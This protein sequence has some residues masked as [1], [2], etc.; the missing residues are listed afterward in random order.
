MEVR[1]DDRFERTP[2][3]NISLD[4][5]CLEF[6]RLMNKHMGADW[7]LRRT[8][9]ALEKM[10]NGPLID[11]SPAERRDLMARVR[12]SNARVAREYFGGELQDSDDPLFRPRSD[13]RPRTSEHVLDGETAV[14]MA[15]ALM[16]LRPAEDPSKKAKRRAARAARSASELGVA[17]APA[18]SS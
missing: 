13:R 2:D 3:A 10:S 14:A 1:A 16:A 8:I 6:L 11:L 5:A 15:A 18:A 4:A 9:V 12:E 17:P 7:K